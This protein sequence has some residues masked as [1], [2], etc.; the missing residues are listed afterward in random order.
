MSIESEIED[1]AELL[2]IEQFC[3]RYAIGGRNEPYALSK[4]G[5]I[6]MVKIGRRTRI[7]A[8]S[9]RAWAAGLPQVHSAQGHDDSGEVH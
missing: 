9:A 6:V 5:Q 1:D 3:R 8:A 2:T 4:R 7:T